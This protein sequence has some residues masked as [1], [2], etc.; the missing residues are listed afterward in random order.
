VNEIKRVFWCSQA[1]NNFNLNC[2]SSSTSREIFLNDFST[3]LQHRSM[4]NWKICE[5]FSNL[6]RLRFFSLAKRFYLELIFSNYWCF[7]S[8]LGFMFTLTLFSSQNKKF[9]SEQISDWFREKNHSTETFNNF[10]YNFICAPHWWEFFN[11][12]TAILA[13]YG[14]PPSF[15][16]NLSKKDRKKFLHHQKI[17][18][19]LKLNFLTCEK[20]FC[21]L[22]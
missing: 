1:C 4:S 16:T 8:R 15:F 2:S 3:S 7:S 10:S 22:T 13:P 18:Q 21:A 17:L 11:F 20:V 19:F 6:T 5:S 14:Y 12:A 9:T